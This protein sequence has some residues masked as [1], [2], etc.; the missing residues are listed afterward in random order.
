MIKLFFLLMFLISG[1]HPLRADAPENDQELLDELNNVKN[2]FD[3]GVPE[4]VPVVVQPPPVVVQPQKPT[5]VRK[6]KSRPRVQPVI[7]L[8]SLKLQGVI[9]EEGNPQA[10]INDNVVPLLGTV[11][12]AQ[13]IAVTKEGVT[14]VYHHKKF[15]LKVD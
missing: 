3:N 9:V 11:E 6:P 7:Q 13:V 2:P 12:G 8:P 5:F 4:P 1:N 14:V 15:F 10:I